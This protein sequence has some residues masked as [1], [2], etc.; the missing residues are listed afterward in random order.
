MRQEHIDK[1]IDTY[2]F[3]KEEV[4]YSRRVPMEEIETNGYNLNISRYISTKMAE[5]E[6]ELGAV[7]EELEILEQKILATKEKHNTFLRELGLRPLP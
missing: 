6:I 3:R 5:D 4:R 2:Q 1:I 7:S